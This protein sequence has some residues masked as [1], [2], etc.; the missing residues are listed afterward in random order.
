MPSLERVLLLLFRVRTHALFP[1][2]ESL[3]Q[4]LAHESSTWHP[5]S[6]LP[7]FFGCPGAPSPASRLSLLHAENG[8]FRYRWTRDRV[9]PVF[10]CLN[11]HTC[12]F[13]LDLDAPQDPFAIA[14]DEAEPV[15]ESVLEHLDNA[16][17]QD[18]ELGFLQ[19]LAET[20]FHVERIT[21]GRLGPLWSSWNAPDAWADLFEEDPGLL[22]FHLPLEMTLRQPGPSLEDDPISPR[23]EEDSTLHKTLLRLRRQ[24]GYRVIRQRSGWTTADSRLI[25]ELHRR[26][27]GMLFHSTTGNPCTP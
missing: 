12:T 7:L 25:L 5:V 13:T 8:V 4:A 10:H 17:L 24:H 14:W 22:V 26:L 18:A 15:P 11:R 3:E 20:G 2:R 9:D 27:P 1:G 6:G 21:R 16:L 23:H 19:C